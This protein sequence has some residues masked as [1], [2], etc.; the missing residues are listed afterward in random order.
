MD[1]DK[2]IISHKR[3]KE[4]CVSKFLCTVKKVHY[5]LN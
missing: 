2:A 5:Q 1:V 4:E 3:Y